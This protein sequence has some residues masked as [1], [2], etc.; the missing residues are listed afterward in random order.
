MH[1]YQLYAQNCG[2]AVW[3]CFK[4]FTIGQEKNVVGEA[5]SSVRGQSSYHLGAK[6]NVTSSSASFTYLSA[7]DV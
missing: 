1:I 3:R 4:L 6:I 7:L 5:Q 2:G